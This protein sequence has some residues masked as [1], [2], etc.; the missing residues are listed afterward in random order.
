MENIES[1]EA[2]DAVSSLTKVQFKRP[3]YLRRIQSKSEPCHEAEELQAAQEDKRCHEPSDDETSS[4]QQHRRVSAPAP[5]PAQHKSKIAQPSKNK[6]SIEKQHVGG[7]DGSTNASASRPTQAG[8][9]TTGSGEKHNSDNPSIYTTPVDDQAVKKASAM[10][11]QPKE[12]LCPSDKRPV[13]STLGGQD[14]RGEDSRGGRR[15]RSHHRYRRR[16][17]RKTT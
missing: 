7:L 15:G 3:R 1:K 16:G 8:K 6:K 11:S 4:G 17:S 12:E 2:P 10:M 14:Q 9:L 5:K 13:D